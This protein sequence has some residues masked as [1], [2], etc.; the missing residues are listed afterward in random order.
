MTLDQSN[1]NASGR[2]DADIVDRLERTISNRREFLLGTVIGA[3]GVG[4]ISGVSMF[5]DGTRIERLATLASG[6]AATF[7]TQYHLP[8]V[9]ANDNGLVVGFTVTLTRGDGDLYVN[10][11]GIEV[12]HDIQLALREATTMALTVTDSSLA[13]QDVLVSFDPP[14]D[15]RMALRGKSWEAGFVVG[16]ASVLADRPLSP[17]TLVTGIVG[18]NGELLPVGSVRSKAIAAREYGADTLLVPPDQATSVSG[19]RVEPVENA[20]ELVHRTLQ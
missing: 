9:D 16:L 11:D 10:L 12:R 8:A 5:A 3:A 15:E 7:Q 2:G 19:I 13:D 14:T 1:E 18:S 20:N 4:G 17:E 6:T